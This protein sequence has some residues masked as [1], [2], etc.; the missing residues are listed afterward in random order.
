MSAS[1]NTNRQ[2]CLNSLEQK[3]NPRTTTCT[4]WATAKNK[5]M[6]TYQGVNKLGSHWF[7]VSSPEPKEFGISRTRSKQHIAIDQ[8]TIYKLFYWTEDKYKLQRVWDLW[9]PL[10]ISFNEKLLLVKIG[11]KGQCKG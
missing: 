11:I 6:D 5:F 3:E 4:K 7:K 10:R 1:S 2:S 8:M 9:Y